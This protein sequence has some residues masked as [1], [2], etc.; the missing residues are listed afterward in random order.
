MFNRNQLTVVFLC[1]F[2]YTQVL[3][4]NL[5]FNTHNYFMAEKILDYL[6]LAE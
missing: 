5:V 6:D 4:E 2:A 3:E 1:V